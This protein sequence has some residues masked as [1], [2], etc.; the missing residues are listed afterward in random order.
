MTKNARN[1]ESCHVSRK[2]L[3]LGIAS[4]RPWN[5]RHFVDLETIDGDILPENTQAQMEPVANLNHDWSQIVDE[6]GN[7]LATVGHHF[8][9]SRAFNKD[10]LDRI[11]REGTCMACHLE[12]PEESLAVSLLHHVAMYSGDVPKT[13][14]EH[15]QLV[16]KIVLSSAWLQI[17]AAIGCPIALFLGIRWFRRRRSRS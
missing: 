13:E 9:L 12:I 14:D 16:H 8:Q 4:T 5:E 6:Q 10:E 7:Q 15:N 17:I 3:G 2:A 1:C 11:S